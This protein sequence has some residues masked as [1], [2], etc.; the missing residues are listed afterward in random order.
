MRQRYTYQPRSGHG[1]PHDPLNAIVGPRPIGWVSSLSASGQRNLAPYSFFNCFNYHPPIIGF[2]S[3]GWKDSVRN[4]S[5][6]K[7]FVWNLATRPLA[8]AMN[9]SSASVPPEQDEFALAGLTPIAASHVNVSMV[10]ES[11]VNFECRLTQL[12]RL[13]DVQG[14]EL[15]SWL[16]LGEVVA[17]HIDEALLEDGIYQTAKAQPILRAGGPSAYYGISED[18]RF[19]LVRP[20]ARRG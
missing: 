20:D 19:D 8:E 9:E 12:I 5:E 17:I 11:P 13:Q 14:T 7:E 3:S 4:I 18:L 10:A 1:L 16:V 6:S 2:A 15:E